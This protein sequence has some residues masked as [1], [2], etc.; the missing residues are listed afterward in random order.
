MK[1]NLLSISMLAVLAAAAVFGES[2]APVPANVA[3]RSIVANGTPKAGENTS[4]QGPSADA[5]ITKGG[6]GR[7]AAL[8]FAGPTDRSLTN[9]ARSLESNLLDWILG[10][11]NPAPPDPCASRKASKKA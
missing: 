3:S 4:N 7:G 8:M 5:V 11:L 9:P 1:T 6:I 10:I 2:S